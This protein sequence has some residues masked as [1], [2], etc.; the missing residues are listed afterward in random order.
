MQALLSGYSRATN[1]RYRRC[2]HLFKQHFYSERK[3]S[4]PAF[5]ELC[6]YIVLNPVR[7]AL[8]ERPEEWPWSS[9]RAAAGMDFSP[10][11][12]ATD[13]LLELFA[14]GAGRAR[15]RVGDCVGGAA[16]AGG[17]FPPPFVPPSRRL[18][19]GGRDPPRPRERYREF[20]AAAH[21]AGVRHRYGSVT[22]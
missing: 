10:P 17:G 5:L 20:V 7:A 21:E 18:P 12:L 11:F 16:E 19:V 9:Y 22:A 3:S 6:R 13:R 8:C 4:E 1:Q 2:D 15:A 14:G